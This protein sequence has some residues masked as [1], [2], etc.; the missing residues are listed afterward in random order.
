MLY[1]KYRVSYYS[2]RGSLKSPVEDYVNKLGTKEKRKIKAYVKALCER[3]GRL[4]M[5]FSRHI[6]EKIWKLRIRYGHGHHRILYFVTSD[7]EIVLLS[8]FLKKSKKTPQSEINTAYNYYL[9][10]ILI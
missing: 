3:E 9:D 8:A 1:F 2:K 7:K 5:P 4:P 10:Y 6:Y